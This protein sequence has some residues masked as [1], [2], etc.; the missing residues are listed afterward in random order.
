MEKSNP[1][2]K[3]DAARIQSAEDKKFAG[4]APKGHFK[5]RAQRA[6]EK[7]STKGEK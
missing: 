3:S 7:N 6:A 1:M 2:T 4:G 5:S